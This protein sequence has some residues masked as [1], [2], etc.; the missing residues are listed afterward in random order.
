VRKVIREMEKEREKERKTKY[1]ILQNKYLTKFYLGTY[2]SW[3]IR[4]TTGLGIKF[5]N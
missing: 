2:K 4:G 1:Y 3:K 5:E